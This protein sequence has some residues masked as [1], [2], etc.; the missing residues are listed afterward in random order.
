A[1]GYCSGVC[2]TYAVKEAMLAKEHNSED[3]DAAVFYIDIRTYG[4]DF[5]RYYNRAKDELGV[6]FIKSKV[7]HIDPDEETGMQIIR[8]VDETGRRVEE[9]FDMV[10]LSVGLTASMQTTSQAKKW[11]I[12][13]DH[14]NFA[15]RLSIPALLRVWQAAGWP[16]LGG[17]SQ[18]PEKSRTKRM[19]GV[20]RPGSVFLSAD[21]E[22]ISRESLMSLK[23]QSLQ[24]TSPALPT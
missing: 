3:L 22:P 2:C 1:N 20:T 8:Y 9:G 10:V 15:S 4:K 13:L 17:H 12:D 23:L 21:A 18:K 16:S 7:T 24:K 5:E 11:G 14:Y 6:R 19:S